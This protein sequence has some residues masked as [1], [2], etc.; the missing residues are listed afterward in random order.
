MIPGCTI[1]G[2]VVAKPETRAELHEILI[3][4]VAPTRAEAGCVNYEFHSDANDPCV[5]VFY[6]NWKTRADL[7]EH[8]TKPHLKPLFDRQGE[9]LA[10][11]VEIRHLTMLSEWIE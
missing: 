9:L 5:F 11:P 10:R 6:E 8:L 3:A 7:D 1:I 4:Q 2:T